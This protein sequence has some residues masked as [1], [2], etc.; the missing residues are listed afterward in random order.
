MIPHFLAVEPVWV[1]GKLVEPKGWL[2]PETRALMAKAQADC[3]ADQK[4]RR[5]R[6]GVVKR[7]VTDDPTT[8]ADD[9]AS[10]SGASNIPTTP[11]SWP[12]D[13]R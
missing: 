13:M 4:V 7:D 11:H 10:G 12:E 9:P 5:E 8:Q 2:S 3:E 6:D 1:N